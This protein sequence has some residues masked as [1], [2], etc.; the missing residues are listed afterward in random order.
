ML[1]I[2]KVFKQGL[3]KTN[4][5]L[6]SRISFVR[7]FFVWLILAKVQNFFYKF[8]QLLLMCI[9]LFLSL[10]YSLLLCRKKIACNS[11]VRNEDFIP[12]KLHD[13]L[14]IILDIVP[15]VYKNASHL[16]HIKNFHLAK[17]FFKPIQ[18]RCADL[19]KLFRLMVL[20]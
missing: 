3:N 6:L 17:F 8:R 20:G 12:T 1:I 9:L 10:I 5:G 4:R 7:F 19:N 15:P 18:Q 11:F 14:K 13:G 2:F 16:M